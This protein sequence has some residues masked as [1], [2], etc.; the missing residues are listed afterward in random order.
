MEREKEKEQQGGRHFML[1]WERRE[2]LREVRRG[3]YREREMMGIIQI[4]MV[5][6]GQSQVRAAVSMPT[7]YPP[8]M[9]SPVL[10]QLNWHI[11][12]AS[13]AHKQTTHWCAG[14][15]PKSLNQSTKSTQFPAPDVEPTVMPVWQDLYI[16]FDFYSWFSSQFICFTSVYCLLNSIFHNWTEKRCE[17]NILLWVI[18]RLNP[19]S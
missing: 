5:G 16:C 10:N 9:P 1:R 18:T 19:L 15:V 11:Q 2:G 4:K 17:C 8:P 7:S 14:N 13:M 3:K 12:G 6:F